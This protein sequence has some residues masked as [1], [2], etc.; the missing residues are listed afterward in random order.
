MLYIYAGL[1]GLSRKIV[2]SGD[3]FSCL[4][5]CHINRSI[6]EIGHLPHMIQRRFEES[7][8]IQATGRGDE[9][10]DPRMDLDTAIATS[11]LDG[12]VCDENPVVVFDDLEK[13]PVFFG[14]KPEMIDVHRHVAA[15]MRGGHEPR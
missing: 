8:L 9:E 5:E 10:N 6:N 15:L 12:V 3:D 2:C 1:A 7:H 11:K 4:I 13:I 14:L